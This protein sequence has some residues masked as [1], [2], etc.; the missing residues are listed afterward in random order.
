MDQ[1]RMA[2]YI[3]NAGDKVMAF[4]C[5]EDI[6]YPSYTAKKGEWLVRNTEG[7]LLIYEAGYFQANFRQKYPKPVDA[8]RE[9]AFVPK[10]DGPKFAA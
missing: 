9:D 2:E 1:L 10:N 3:N 7:K 4:F 6:V 8:E 5:H